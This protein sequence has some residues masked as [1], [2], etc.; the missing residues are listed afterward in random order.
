M[1]HAA[2]RTDDDEWAEIRARMVTAQ[3]E[4]RGIRDARVLDAMSRV[5]R[6]LFVRADQ[7]AGAYEDRAL[8]IGGGQSI[9]Q[10]Y[11]VASMTAALAVPADGRVL[12][13]GTGSGYQ[14]AV[15][16]H[17]AREVVTIERLGDLAAAARDRL[18]S[19]GYGNVRVIVADG[20]AGYPDLAPYDGILVTAGA[21]RVPEGLKPQLADGARLVVPVG[22]SAGQTIVVVAR[23]GEGYTTTSGDRCIFVPLI[24]AEGWPAR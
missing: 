16:A 11:M 7:A 10:P 8:P 4:R 13:I 15:L 9:S 24:G 22:P 23:R 5:P 3:L 19:L 12:E 14:A 17:L 20:S 18:A 21:P 1:D 6:H 2:R